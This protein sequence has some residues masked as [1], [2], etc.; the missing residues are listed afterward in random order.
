MVDFSKKYM[1]DVNKPKKKKMNRFLYFTTHLFH[2]A[3]QGNKFNDF[4]RTEIFF[5]TFDGPI[6]AME[7]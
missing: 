3:D 7:E 2:R 1:W 4:Y 5:S 6:I